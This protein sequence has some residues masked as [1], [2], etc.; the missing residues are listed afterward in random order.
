MLG[1]QVT[2]RLGGFLGVYRKY[3]A[4]PQCSTLLRFKVS[5]LSWM[6]LHSHQQHPAAMLKFPPAMRV[7]AHGRAAAGP[8]LAALALA[9]ALAGEADSPLLRVAAR[10]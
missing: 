5:R 9:L 8:A 1:A 7:R 6:E 10:R 3:G 2:A 4:P